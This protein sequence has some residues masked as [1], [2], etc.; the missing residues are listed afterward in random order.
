MARLLRCLQV[1]FGI[2]AV[3]L[4]LHGLILASDFTTFGLDLLS[5][6]PLRAEPTRA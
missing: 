1:L 5:K 2:A 4:T 3:Q 6:P